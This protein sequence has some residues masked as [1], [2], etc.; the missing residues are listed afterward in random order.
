[1]QEMEEDDWLSNLEVEISTFC[2]GQSSIT[3]TAASRCLPSY[4]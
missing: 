3:C 2:F 4:R 1:V